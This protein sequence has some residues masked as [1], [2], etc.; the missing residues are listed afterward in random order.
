VSD[1][2]FLLAAGMSWLD[3]PIWAGD[4]DGLVVSIELDG[5]V[6]QVQLV[7]I[8]S[9]SADGGLNMFDLLFLQDCIDSQAAMPAIGVDHVQFSAL[10]QVGQRFG[11]QLGIINVVGRHLYFGD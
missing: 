5:R 3:L 7:R 4:F 2:G 11:Q 8:E 1:E 6:G 9:T 10:F